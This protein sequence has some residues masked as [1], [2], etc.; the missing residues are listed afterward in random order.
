MTTTRVRIDPDDPGSL[1]E[2]KVNCAVLDGTSEADLVS[3]QREDGAEATRDM[4]RLP[5][6]KVPN[7]RTRRAMAEAE[8][9]MRRGTA[10]FASAEEMFA[11]LDEVGGQ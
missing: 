2:G 1:P 3:Q 10:Q 8:E 5:R 11:E 6:R 9:M 4:A 7:A